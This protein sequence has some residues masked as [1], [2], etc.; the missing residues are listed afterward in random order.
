MTD[1]VVHDEHTLTRVHDALVRSGLTERQA[2]EAI[3]ECLN[4]GILFRETA[5]SMFGCTKN[6]CPY[7]HSEMHGD[8]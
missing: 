5:R 6:P 3:N 7:N 1:H 8:L 2:H 4:T